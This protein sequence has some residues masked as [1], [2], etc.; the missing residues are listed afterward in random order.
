MVPDTPVG[1]VH[2]VFGAY[3][4]IRQHTSAYVSIRQHTSAYLR[5]KVPDTPVGEV[6]FV[7]GGAEFAHHSAAY[8][9]IRTSYVSIRQHTSAYAYVRGALRFWRR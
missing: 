3:I 7:F 2:F 8:V 9:I 1:E 5:L 6:H 4:S